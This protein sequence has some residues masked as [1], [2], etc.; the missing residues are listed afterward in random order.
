MRVMRVSKIDRTIPKINL[1]NVNGPILRV[2]ASKNQKFK[3][4]IKLFW[5]FLFELESS[6]VN[7]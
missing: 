4:S 3:S 6:G 1:K 7:S 2:V 5:E